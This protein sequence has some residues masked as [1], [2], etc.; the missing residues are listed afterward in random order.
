MTESFPQKGPGQ[1]APVPPHSKGGGDPEGELPSQLRGTLV[2]QAIPPLVGLSHEG[3]G[4]PESPPARARV[5]LASGAPSLQPGPPQLRQTAQRGPGSPPG[6]APTTTV[7][8]ASQLDQIRKHIAAQR[9]LEQ[10]RLGSQVDA[11]GPGPTSAESV[12]SDTDPGVITHSKLRVPVPATWSPTPEQQRVVHTILHVELQG[13]EDRLMPPSLGNPFEGLM[14]ETLELRVTPDM[15][16]RGSAR[17]APDRDQVW[18]GPADTPRPQLANSFGLTDEAVARSFKTIFGDA[19]EYPREVLLT[20]GHLGRLEAAIVRTL[21]T[22]G[23]LTLHFESSRQRSALFPPEEQELRT[24][25]EDTDVTAAITAL[26][27]NQHPA[28][29]WKDDD[30]S[31]KK[32]LRL[33][34]YQ[35]YRKRGETIRQLPER[36]LAVSG[37]AHMLK[38]EVS[39]LFGHLQERTFLIRQYQLSQIPGISTMFLSQRGLNA[40][41]GFFWLELQAE[42]LG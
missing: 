10:G 28:K 1:R 6:A 41:P 23:Q 7:L 36:I 19:R 25:L 16:E 11:I 3:Q 14:N 29:F 2:S 20:F 38:T 12:R 5:Q 32:G 21:G 35:L 39:V 15:L 22:L 31:G 17:T 33:V 8:D 37:D 18:I 26:Q 34:G 40:A 42:E 27:N 9:A 13:T 24:L 4:G 30:G